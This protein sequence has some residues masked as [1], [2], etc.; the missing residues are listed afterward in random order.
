M[1]IRKRS[2]DRPRAIQYSHQ[3]KHLIMDSFTTHPTTIA[4][5]AQPKN[6]I[7]QGRSKNKWRWHLLEW[8]E[9]KAR[10]ID[11]NVEKKA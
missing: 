2:K 8:D 7:A 10:I 3:P 1:K 6:Q 5:Q 11:T 4:K 9:W